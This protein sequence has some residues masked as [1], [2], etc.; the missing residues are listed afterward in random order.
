MFD[1]L[2]EAVAG[3]STQAS[4]EASRQDVHNAAS[5]APSALY[6]TVPSARVAIERAAGHAAFSAFGID[7]MHLVF[8]LE[9]DLD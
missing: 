6:A 4:I 5:N 1:A 8:V 2:K 9:N 3:P 7:R